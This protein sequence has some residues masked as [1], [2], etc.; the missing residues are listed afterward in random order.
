MDSIIQSAFERTFNKPTEEEEDKDSDSG[1]ENPVEDKDREDNWVPV[2]DKNES[3]DQPVMTQPAKAPTPEPQAKPFENFVQEGEPE[4]EPEPQPQPIQEP[5]QQPVQQP[6]QPVQQPVQPVQPAPSQEWEPVEP[7]QTE[8]LEDWKD[9]SEEPW[10][11][12]KEEP[13]PITQ[14]T[15]PAKEE[16]TES[17][18][19]QQEL[20][21]AASKANIVVVGCGCAGSNTINRLSEMNIEGAITMAA[22]ADA[23]HLSITKADKRVLIGKELTKGLGC[24]GDPELGKRA[25]EETKNDLKTILK[26]A[27]LVF[28]TCGLGG[29]TGSGSAPVVAQIAKEN[30]A[31]V[32]ATVT[33]PF[34]IEGARISKAEDALYELRQICDT[35]IVI[36]NQKL[37]KYAGDLS[38]KQA[39]AVADELISTM[40]KGLTEMIA[41]P[42][43]VNLDF[44]DVKTIMHSGGVATIG[45]GESG[46]KERAKEAVMKALNHPLLEVNY[47]GAT[48]ALIQII[49]GEDLKLDE[50]NEIGEFICN[51]L[52][53]E[54]TIMWGARVDPAYEGKIQ[55]ITIVTGVKSPYILGRLMKEPSSNKSISD[56]LG[57]EVVK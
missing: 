26:E 47:A 55:V 39:F 16:K 51:Q 32:I 5:V 27:D 41:T 36:E 17:E 20:E 7:Q 9:W 6:T 46:T 21:I 42:S 43:L 50:V 33:L 18:L 35:V 57:I 8:G 15:Q 53:P 4:P 22:D 12:E 37:L 45:I 25:A 13:E 2:G 19:E 52:S 3:W 23:R 49:G 44:A 24:G 29:G 10:E 11:E 28:I 1:W 14:W 34:K 48:G 38:L 56:E 31:I 54:A 40:I 30:N